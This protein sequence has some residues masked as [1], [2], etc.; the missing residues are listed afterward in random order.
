MS[1][2][3][4]V[5]RHLGG[6]RQAA[7][8]T[9]PPTSR[10]AGHGTPHAASDLVP[11]PSRQPPGRQLP[12]R[13][14]AAVAVGATGCIL[15]N[16]WVVA[17]FDRTFIRTPD[18]LFSDLETPGLPHSALFQHLDLLSGA[19][20][21]TALLLRG[22]AAAD[23]R[24]AEWPWL[25]VFAGA[26]AMGGHFTYACAE[27]LSPRCRAAEWHL[28]LPL[29][30]YLHMGAGIVEFGAATVAVL[31]AR[32]RTAG[33]GTGTARVAHLA[34]D[35]LMAAYPLLAVSYLSHVDGAVVEPVFFLAFTAMMTAE[36]LE[37]SGPVARPAPI[38]VP[39]PG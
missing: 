34:A 15:Y 22:P 14:L 8:G 38:P 27:G 20:L 28:Q 26:A 36:L 39:Q 12:G 7:F 10:T 32:H 29:H 2:V 23:G 37:P 21:L 11:A 31:L 33:M 17:A 3:G 25:V 19:L 13:Q 30:H 1:P 4:T 9:A 18:Q 6:L 24:R 16:W 35:V 5:L